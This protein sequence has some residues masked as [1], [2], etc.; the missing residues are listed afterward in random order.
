MWVSESVTTKVKTE[1][2]QT[3]CP[4]SQP[5]HMQ[6]QNVSGKAGVENLPK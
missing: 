1:D 4:M 3:E 2:A 6:K 5:G